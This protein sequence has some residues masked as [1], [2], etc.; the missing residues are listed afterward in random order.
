[1][2]IRHLNVMRSSI[3]DSATSRMVVHGSAASS[4]GTLQCIIHIYIGIY[5]LQLWGNAKKIQPK[6]NPIFPKYSSK[7]VK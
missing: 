6:Q 1:M 3:A 4:Y 5:G 2:A 7:K